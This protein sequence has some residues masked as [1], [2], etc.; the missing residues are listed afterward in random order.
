MPRAQGCPTVFVT[1][2]LGLR[3]PLFYTRL[4]MTV[5]QAPTCARHDAEVKMDLRTIHTDATRPEVV[6]GNFECPECG[7]EKRVPMEPR[8]A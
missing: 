2:R 8:A 3:R 1:G 7:Y 5:D 4:A 6:I